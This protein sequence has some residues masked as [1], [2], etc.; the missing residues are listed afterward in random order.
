M[1]IPPRLICALLSSSKRFLTLAALWT[2]GVVPAANAALT[3]SFTYDASAGTIV[4][5]ETGSAS[6]ESTGG[7]LVDP[8]TSV[9]FSGGIFVDKVGAIIAS[10][11]D[12]LQ[13]DGPWVSGQGLVLYSEATH[14]ETT[15]SVG[16][17]HYSESG[18]VP[19]TSTGSD[20]IMFYLSSNGEQPELNDILV[21]YDAGSNSLIPWDE[22]TITLTESSEGALAQFWSDLSVAIGSGLY[23]ATATEAEH[24]LEMQAVTVNV[25]EPRTCA[26]LLGVSCLLVL[27]FRRLRPGRRGR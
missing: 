27:G 3:L 19:T 23:Y 13:G 7:G 2:F 12:L 5:Q 21:R 10:T 18:L 1:N 11:N 6:P 8:E 20:V 24:F 25:P 22:A 4:I 16:M 17:F 15:G 9:D 26:A 14:T